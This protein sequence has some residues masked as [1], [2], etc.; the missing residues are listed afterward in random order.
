MQSIHFLKP[1]LAILPLLLTL[2]SSNN[3]SP[4]DLWSPSWLCA[5]KPQ[6]PGSIS[7]ED[8]GHPARTHP[9][10]RGRTNLQAILKDTPPCDFLIP[11]H[12]CTSPM[13]KIWHSAPQPAALPQTGC[14]NRMH[15]SQLQGTRLDLDFPTNLQTSSAILSESA[16]FQRRIRNCTACGFPGLTSTNEN[17]QRGPHLVTH[18]ST[19]PKTAETLFSGVSMREGA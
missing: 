3:G 17:E 9:P 18:K 11:V 7:W 4:S 16:L 12:I 8:S 2:L 5:H 13:G 6:V 15:S 1:K 14:G 10:E 19:E